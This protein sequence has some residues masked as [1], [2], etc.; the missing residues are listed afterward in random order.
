MGEWQ[1]VGGKIVKGQLI[2]V[3]TRNVRKA[4]DSF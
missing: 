4:L 3:M 2:Q 1:E